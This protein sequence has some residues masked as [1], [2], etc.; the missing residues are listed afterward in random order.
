MSMYE[1]YRP[2]N[3]ASKLGMLSELHTNELGI[4]KD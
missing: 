1:L 2:I 3:G 4:L